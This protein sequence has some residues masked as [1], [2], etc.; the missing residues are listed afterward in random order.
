MSSPWNPEQYHRFQ[1][2]RS[3]PFFDLLDLVEPCPG[4]TVIDLGCGT[5]ELTKI[6][7]EK[8]G[9]ASTLGYD[10]SET[11]LGQAAQYA[12]SG[13]SFAQGDI[14]HFEG[15]YDI[16]FSNA[17]L[18]WLND[19]NSLIPFVSSH[20]RAGGQL[21]FQVPANADHP[22][23][24][25]AYS[26]AREEPF[27]SAL[28]GYSREWPVLPPEIYAEMLDALGFR[29]LTVR[30]QVYGHHLQ[31]SE[32]VIEWVKGTLLTDYE[33]RMPADLYQRYLARYRERL[34]S[35]IGERAPYFYAFKR[36]LV[37]GRKLA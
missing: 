34:L 1:D 37:R 20:V 35:E 3:Q 11:M 12:G 9:A 17:A 26:V 15:D 2:E 6:L 10:S 16:V 5:G 24:L 4:G 14:A 21:A 22:S 8:S 29:D 23:H 19:H 36:I 32:G 31:S 25:V 28:G 18:Q 27:A 13:L 33:R 7:H 30:L